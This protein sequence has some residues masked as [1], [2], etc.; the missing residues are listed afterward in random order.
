MIY[1]QEEADDSNPVIN[2]PGYVAELVSDG[3]QDPTGMAFIGPNE[4]LVT[5]KTEGTVQKISNGEMLEA[6]LLDL[7]VNARD[8]RGLLGIA[9]A[10]DDGS[11]ET[12]RYV[13]LY[14]TEAEEEDGGE[15]LGNRLYRY[16]L[17][18]DSLINGTLL[19]DLP[20]LP[21][22]AHNGGVLSIGPDKNVYLAIG[23]MTPTSYAETQYRSKAQNYGA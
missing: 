13:F 1:G 16:E 11:T 18:G 5:E 3:L 6:P 4:I 17:T 10:E 12:P 7:N 14:Y 9:V 20:Y 8:E 19:L 15:P 22:P 21:G 2:R 23:D